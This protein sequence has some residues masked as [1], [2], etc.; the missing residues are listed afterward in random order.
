MTTR[1][2][3]PGAHLLELQVNGVRYAP[4]EFFVRTDTVEAGAVI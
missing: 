3:H 2:H 1:R 4:T